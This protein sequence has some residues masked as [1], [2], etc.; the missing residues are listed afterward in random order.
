MHRN[1]NY[2]VNHVFLPPQLPQKDDHDA[3]KDAALIEKFVEAL[4]LF[5]AY[6]PDHEFPEWSSCIKMANSMLELRAHSGDL[7]PENVV[8]ALREMNIRGINELALRMRQVLNIIYVDLDILPLHIRAQNAGLIIR[9]FSDQYSFESFELSP[10]NGAVIGTVG[11]LRRC[12]PGAAIAIG[13]DRIADINFVEPLADLLARLDAQTPEE[14]MPIIRKAN[15]EVVEIRDTSHPRFVTEMVTGILRAIGQPIDVSRIHKHTREDILWKDALRPWRRSPMWLFLRVTLQTSL[16]DTNDKISCLNYKF[17]MVF[18][19]ANVLESALE[20]SLPTEKLF[21][22]TAKISRRV[23]KLGAL[24]DNTW[25][26]YVEK[27]VGSAQQE[28]TRRWELVEKNSDPLM[29]RRNWHPSKLSF[30]DDTKLSLPKLRPYLTSVLTRPAITSTS[31]YFTSACGRRILQ[32]SSEL[33]DL[34]LLLGAG[35]D[36]VSL[37]LVDLERWV[38]ESLDS[39]LL[40]N[41]EREDASTNLSNLMSAYTTAASSAYVDMPEDISLMLLTLMDLWVALDR[42]ALHHYPIL[43]DYDPGF[44]PSVFEPLLL[45]R[46]SQMERLLH[47][48]QYLESRRNQTKPNYPSIFKSIDAADSFSVRYFEKSP[49]HQK[50][51]KMIEA[52]A[53]A[54]RTQKIAELARKIQQHRDLI[55][56]SDRLNC[57]FVTTWRNRKG[58]T[59][60]SGSCQK[61]RLRATANSISIE[62][63]E[64][65]LP[66]EDLQAKAVVFE[67]DMPNVICKW[68][69][70]TYCLLVDTLSIETGRNLE[71][72]I[73]TLYNYDGASEFINSKEARVQLASTTKPFAVSHYRSKN[74]SLANEA[75]ICVNNGLHYS[76]YDSKRRNWTE[77]LLDHFDIREKCTPKL[78]N[79][80]YKGLQYT[81][82]NTIHTSN[83]VIAGQ[84][85]CPAALTLHEFYAY[86]TLRSGHRLQWRNIIR[87][88]TTNILN[89]SRQETHALITQAAWQAGPSEEKT[90]H[91]ESHVDLEEKGFGMSLG[92][93]L[94]DAISAVES[95]WQGAV[96]VRT[97]IA[98]ASRLLSFSRYNAVREDCARFLRRARKISLRWTREIGQK[99]QDEE[100]EKERRTLNMQ[101][102]EMALTCYGTFDVEPHQLQRLF[103]SDEDV[104]IATEC[105]II[106]HDRCPAV[107]TNVPTPMKALLQR[108]RRISCSL[109]SALRDR[110]VGGCVGLDNTLR[111]LW[112]GYRSGSPW[113]AMEAPSERW[114]VTKISSEDSISSM[115]VHYNLLDGSL[116]VNGSPLTRL[117][118]SYESHPTFY[119][120]FGEV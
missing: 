37:H 105:S 115:L 91:R 20:A 97:F 62:V 55:E 50:L 64:W 54:E 18:F 86:G 45:P 36:S 30:L 19:M 78:S 8:T 94:N 66:N 31:C 7:V 68:R 69:D 41:V 28:M 82:N 117:P 75:N 51:R 23:L 27:V 39:W 47:V 3:S 44:P 98:L 40:K 5:K 113:K 65:P 77:E 58:R 6:I 81:L 73:Y 106:V 71:P 70:T 80:P 4:S 102:L 22:M 24:H 53:L 96:A 12:F 95:N 35:S 60:H 42:C 74:I 101:T 1:L 120:L 46:K 109:E 104:A 83:D 25:L 16:L 59:V 21:I 114:L 84:D 79:G 118:R 32:S 10:T 99:L 111:L 26:E 93:T 67:L 2:I 87:E 11:R 34:S 63:H 57:E 76:L 13:Q 89:F 48:E 9:R 108:H 52:K 116:L 92:S 112:G 85:K 49:H 107:T 29:T 119:R 100:R 90:L 88:L 72:K 33:P 61:C 14:A 103:E 43:R 17:F 110:I 38:C 56:R 15:S